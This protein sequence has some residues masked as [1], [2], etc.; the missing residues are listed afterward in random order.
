MTS[1]SGSITSLLEEHQ[2]MMQRHLQ[3]HLKEAQEKQLYITEEEVLDLLQAHYDRLE[4]QLKTQP[5]QGEEDLRDSFGVS[6]SQFFR[7]MAQYFG[8]CVQKIGE[9]TSDKYQEIMRNTQAKL[10]EKT[11]LVTSK[12]VAITEE[13][14]KTLQPT[15]ANNSRQQEVAS[16]QTDKK[17]PQKN[18]QPIDKQPKKVSTP[19]KTN[20]PMQQQAPSVQQKPEVSTPKNPPNEGRATEQKQPISTTKN[21]PTSQK[22]EKVTP[23]EKI[24][25]QGKD[26]EKQEQDPQMDSLFGTLIPEEKEAPEII[27][28]HVKAVKEDTKETMQAVGKVIDQEATQQ[29]KVINLQQLETI[30]QEREERILSM[31]KAILEQKNQPSLETSLKQE[32]QSTIQKVKSAYQGTKAF[33]KDNTVGRVA[34]L[35]NKMVHQ[36]RQTALKMNQKLYNFA[37]NMDEKLQ[38]KQQMLEDNPTKGQL[39]EVYPEMKEAGFTV[40]VQEEPFLVRYKQE[41]NEIV[42]LQQQ[43]PVK[44]LPYS[45]DLTVD[46]IKEAIQEEQNV[47]EEETKEKNMDV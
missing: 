42:M 31:M 17:E 30:L 34:Q 27:Q 10:V 20:N 7:E 21:A 9:I 18:S 47:E 16:N 38:S 24:Q 29:G 14:Q 11:Q 6:L 4:E 3:L 13:K 19:E 2:K 41:T 1:L 37:V 5:I 32:R 44:T 45:K 33:V 35:K 28:P 12:L 22:T 26:T 25:R 15:Y 39:L 40:T 8:H 23:T 36:L 46:Q 43:E